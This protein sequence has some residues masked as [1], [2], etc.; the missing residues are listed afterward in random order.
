M[1]LSRRVL[2]AGLAGS[3][4]AAAQSF[5]PGLPNVGFRADNVP[6]RTECGIGALMPWA[7]GLYAITYNSHKKATGTG[8]GLYRLNDSLKPELVRLHNGTHANRL[9]HHESNQCIIGPYIIDSGGKVRFIEAFENH[10]LTSTMRHLVDPHNRVYFLTMEGLVFEMDVATLKT[11]QLF[12][13]VKDMGISQP[14]HFKGAYTA[15]QRVVAANNGFYAYGD[16]NAGLFEWDGGG[17]W[18]R[19]S[20]KPHMDVAAR[21]NMGNVMFTSGWD[22]S[23]ALLSALVEGKWQ[24]YRLPKASH[25]TEQAWQ[26]EWMRIRE[27][28][29]E[30]FMLDIQGMFYELQPVAFEGRI[31]GVKPVCQ[32]LRIIPDY[33]AFRGLLALGGNQTTPNNDNNAVVGQPQSGLW[34]GKTDDLWGWGKPQGWGGPWRAARVQAGDP[35]DPF[36]FTGFERKALH[37]VAGDA[38]DVAIEVD[39]L[40]NGTW[41]PFEKVKL[42]S[43]EYKFF[44]FPD[45]FSAHWVRLIPSATST[46]TAEFM[47]T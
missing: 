29:T 40:G 21:Q 24:K 2:L 26:T 28:E 18:R 15:Q 1:P 37:L 3:T 23:S 43:G 33:C 14:P 12:D 20:N 7:D 45:A 22:E 16:T 6:E 5:L 44:P 34:L 13:L 47:F 8:L 41:E 32:H 38:T 4:F 36:L 39:F 9:I 10:R 46:I 31:W 42:G 30:H 11:R 17:S 35:S 19:I 27:V 25:A